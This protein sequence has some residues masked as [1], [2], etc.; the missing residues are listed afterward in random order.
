MPRGL[1]ATSSTVAIGFDVAETAPSTFTQSTV[2]LNLDPLNLEVFVVQAIDLQADFPDNIAGISTTV[3]SA[4]TTTSQTA[5]P[6]LS[7]TNCLAITESQIRQEFGAALAAGVGFQSNSMDTPPAGLEYIG[8]IATNNFFL[9]VEGTSN[10]NIK[11]LQGKLYGYRARADASIY[12]ALVQSEV[13][14]A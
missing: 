4:M 10:G 14:S 11:Q 1:K 7:D 8:I 13:L 2:D 3:N 12:S 6:T 5:M 9:Q